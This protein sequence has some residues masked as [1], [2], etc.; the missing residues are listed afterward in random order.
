[1][2]RSCGACYHSTYDGVC[3]RHGDVS[4]WLYQASPDY[5]QWPNDFEL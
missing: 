2:G 5:D 1:M 4:R 3:H